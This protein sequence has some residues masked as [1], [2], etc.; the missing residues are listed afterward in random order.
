M[1]YF[2]F[3][4][5]VSAYAC[6]S[7]QALSEEIILDESKES[8][9]EVLDRAADEDK[10]V[11]LDLYT[12]WCLPCQ[13]MDEIVYTD[14]IILEYLNEN[15]INLKLNAEKG[16]GP[17]LKVIYEIKEYPTLLFLDSKG[18]ILVRKN[19]AAFQKELVSLG[20]SALAMMKTI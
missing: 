15:F 19:G 1:K 4:F 17:D 20:D 12:D 13:L 9:V 18:K 14:P 2:I 16:E 7:K 5:I 8:F 11:F 10:I 3:A 6:K